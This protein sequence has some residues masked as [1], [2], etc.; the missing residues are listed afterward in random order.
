MPPMWLVVADILALFGA[1]LLLGVLFERLGQ[2]ALVGYLLAG[3]LLGPGVL[4]VIHD[5]E[6][7]RH[8]AEIGVALLLFTIGLEF[9]WSRMRALGVV[10]LLGGALQVSLTAA[11]A[12]I[13]GR[14]IGLSWSTAFGI[15]L[16]IAPSST[17]CVLRLLQ[18]RAELDSVHGR[19]TTGVLLFQDAALVPLVLGVTLLGSGG[20][21]GSVIGKLLRSVGL[22]A[23][24]VVLLF[25]VTRYVLPH[26]INAA[27]LSRNRELPLLLAVFMCMGASWGAHE[28]ELS[29]VLGA[30]L[31]GVLLAGSPYATWV[32]ADAAALRTLFIT[33]FFASVAMIDNLHWVTAHWHWVV[34]IVPGVLVGKAMIAAMSARICGIRPGFALGAGVCLAQT[35]EFSFVLAEIAEHG[36]LISND[37]FRLV[38]VTTVLTIVLTPTLV[39]IA[40]SITRAGQ[41]TEHQS[42]PAHD[43]DHAQLVNHTVIVGFGPAG[44]AVH[45][46]ATPEIETAVIDLNPRGASKLARPPK[47]FVA[48][49]AAQEAVLLHAGVDRARAVVITMPDHVVALQV[50]RLVR[51]LAPAA[52]LFVRARLHIFAGPLSAE[53][54][55]IA[56]EERLVG[57]AL[58]RYILDEYEIGKRAED[59]EIGHA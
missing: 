12:A 7:I 56:D 47:L 34:L 30:F 1:A 49:D 53:A 15:G 26:V 36:G 59:A 43:D 45:R 25:G 32:R 17:A 55:A 41:R 5:R 9:S 21:D 33:L 38:V 19:V 35:G 16:I 39:K 6:T 13:A 31:A 14:T 22:G 24:F 42:A 11:V 4:G 2:S 58:A 28:L 8:F 37:L 3:V 50:A 48:G 52:K 46:A 18:Q 51:E 20:G 23:I 54:T 29:P 44:R 27:V 40:P 57:D 10:A